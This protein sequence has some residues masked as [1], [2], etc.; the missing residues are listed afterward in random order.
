MDM[1]FGFIT[2]LFLTMFLVPPLI[3]AASYLGIVDKPDGVRK[4]HKQV[5][6]RVGGVAMVIAVIIS[7]FLWS[8]N[9]TN[10]LLSYIVGATIIFAFGLWDDRNDIDYKLKFLGQLLAILPPILYGNIQIQYL[11]FL[12]PE[13]AIPEYL[14]IPITIFVFLGITNAINLSD[15]LDGLAGGTSLLIF[16]VIA[17]LSYLADAM[18]LVLIAI[19]VMGGILG[20]LR[21]NTHPAQ[22]FMGDCGSQFLG[23]SAGILAV[24]ASQKMNT[25]LSLMLPILILG[26]PILDTL[27]VM[28]QRVYEKRS[29][30]SPDKNHLHH[31]LLK[32]RF[33]QHEAVFLI[34]II[35]SA[36]VV[37]A[38]FF[39]YESDVFILFVYLL[40][41]WTILLFFHWSNKTGWVLHD[42]SRGKRKR[43]L[44][45]YISWLKDKNII[46]NISALVVACAVAFYILNSIWFSNTIS[47]DIS[48]LAIAIC[49]LLT[50][51]Q[52]MR[53]ESEWGQWLDRVGI[54][55]SIAIFVYAIESSTSCPEII[56]RILD[57]IIIFIAIAVAINIRYGKDKK[58]TATPL[59]YLVL[60]VA[61]SLPFISADLQ[62]NSPL[63]V[64]MTKVIV[65]FYGAELLLK[66]FIGHSKYIRLVLFIALFSIGSKGILLS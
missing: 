11:P 2:A 61:I 37:S 65:I 1:L 66:Y 5:I 23:F 29:P 59:D 24:W 41:C 55:T 31:K 21:F 7:L 48:V 32:L 28:M 19:A 38:Y 20:F 50:V 36:L 4:V 3:R 13:Q 44:S 47:N 46:V 14:S 42:D 27:T 30:F 35:Q 64:G 12:S 15:G 16:A 10:E 49:I 45:R 60:F 22:I 25:A 8:A 52:F 40:F 17:V 54:Y 56:R 18:S 34:Y 6:P 53:I 26:L 9:L 33:D 63:A 62:E 51:S 43:F 58:L 57:S 39:R